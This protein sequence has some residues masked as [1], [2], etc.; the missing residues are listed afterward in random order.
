MNSQM[1]EAVN[2][3]FFGGQ[4][5]KNIDKCPVCNEDIK[6]F[7]DSISKEEYELSGMCQD[8]QDK[9]FSDRDE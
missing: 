8:C 1:W 9:V 3:I 5:N 6:E 2:N 4:N 7:K